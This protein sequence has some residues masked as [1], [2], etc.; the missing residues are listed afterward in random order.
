MY[1]K[2]VFNS[3]GDLG[4]MTLALR[5]NTFAG[6][7]L[8]DNLSA[9][10][11]LHHF[12]FSRVENILQR[13]TVFSVYESH[14]GAGIPESGNFTILV[15]VSKFMIFAS[16]LEAAMLLITMHQVCLC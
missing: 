15:G 13:Y 16:L 11:G 9:K 2:L 14:N 10:Y 6:H 3:N 12:R 4:E 8:I 7:S 1:M 5:H